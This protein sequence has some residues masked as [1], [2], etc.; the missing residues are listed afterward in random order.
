MAGKGFVPGFIC[1]IERDETIGVYH[2][3]VL[4]HFITGGAAIFG[5]SDALAVSATFGGE[6]SWWI[7]RR[8]QPIN[9]G[10]R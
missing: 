1:S 10:V 5:D 3:P 2:Q 8:H 7:G 4:A 6:M 9:G